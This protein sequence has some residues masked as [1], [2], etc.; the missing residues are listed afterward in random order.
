MAIVAD[1]AI[2]ELGESFSHFH[3]DC[4]I[5]CNYHCYQLFPFW[6]ELLFL[7]YK[8]NHPPVPILQLEMR[9]WGMFCQKESINWR[10]KQ[11]EQNALHCD[12]PSNLTL[13]HMDSA[14][15]G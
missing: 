15:H 4:C 9:G 13:I 8:K 5:F 14:H 10:G 6:K 3:Y 2:T 12:N 1:F 7:P 11:G